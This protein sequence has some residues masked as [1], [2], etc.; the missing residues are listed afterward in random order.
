[1][2]ANAGKRFLSLLLA[3]VMIVS[4]LPS[5]VITAYALSEVEVA[6]GLTASTTG[7]SDSFENGTLIVKATGTSGSGCGSSDSSGT[8]TLT[9]TNKLDGDAVLQFKWTLSN[10]GSVQFG[11]DT[12]ETGES[13]TKTATNVKGTEYKV[14][15]TSATGNNTTTLTITEIVFKK[16]EESFTTQ[17]QPANGGSY[18]VNDTE[19]TSTQNIT[20]KGSETL[21]L[22]ATA[23]SG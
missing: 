12:T 16:A 9:L 11:S 15:V 5:G 7:D 14:I 19:I 1:M 22:T 2:I 21:T 17:F 13:G 23:S 3:L 20:H 18:T 10:A 6:S 8:N 4:L